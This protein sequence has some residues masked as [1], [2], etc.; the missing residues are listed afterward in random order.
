MTDLEHLLALA[1]SAE[2]AS[3]KSTADIL[4]RMRLEIERLRSEK[5]AAVAAEREACAKVAEMII[6]SAAAIR[7]RGGGHD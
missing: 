2:N 1:E 5:Q 3:T 7:S 4:R 6:E